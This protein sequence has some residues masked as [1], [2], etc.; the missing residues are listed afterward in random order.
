MTTMLTLDKPLLDWLTFTGHCHT[1]IVEAFNSFLASRENNYR[2]AL[3]KKWLQ[4]LGTEFSFSDGSAFAGMG[5]IKRQDWHG[6]TFSGELCQDAL[7]FFMPLVDMGIVTCKRVD[8]QATIL[9]PDEW[10]QITF[11]NR[12][13]VKGKKPEMRQSTDKSTGKVLAT[14][15]VGSRTSDVYARVYQKLTD[16]GDR[17]LRFEGEYKGGKAEAIIRDMKKHA[18]S[19]MLWWHVQKLRD[20]KTENAFANAFHG[21]SPHKAKPVVKVHNK[22]RA[23]LLESCLP[24][25]AEFIHSHDDDGQVQAEFLAVLHGEGII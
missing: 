21:I 17:L 12:M 7:T 24:A 6:V 23:W 2:R 11:H 14:V 9:E 16:S 10:E 5:E 4:F 20:A 13:H 8:I 25:F 18:P 19:T 3:D 15:G 22:K 1:D